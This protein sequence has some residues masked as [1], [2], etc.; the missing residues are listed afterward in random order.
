MNNDKEMIAVCGLVC[1]KC[2]I[3]RATDDK[4]VAQETVDWFKRE[5][6]QDLKL[7]DVHCMGC[8][9]DR[10]RHWSADCWILQCCV[11]RKG[12]E[13]CYQCGE[14]PCQELTEWSKTS[15]RYGEALDRLGRRGEQEES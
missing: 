3:L 7:E 13:H 14:F 9:E 6:N 4:K 10:S 5:L 1:H 8:K 2:D 15:K 11:D 12:L